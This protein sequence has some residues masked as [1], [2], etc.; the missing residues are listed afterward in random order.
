MLGEALLAATLGAALLITVR[1]AFEPTLT[2]EPASDGAVIALGCLTEVALDT[3]VGAFS[4][5][6]DSEGR[7]TASML[8]PSKSITAAL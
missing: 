1:A 7:W 3:T 5:L 2:F 8:L 6:S 4:L